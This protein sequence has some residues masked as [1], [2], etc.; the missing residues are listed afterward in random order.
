MN[1][2]VEQIVGVSFGVLLV[3]YLVVAP[4]ICWQKGKQVATVI[5]IFVPIVWLLGAVKY[6]KPGSP[7]VERHYDAEKRRKAREHFPRE[8]ARQDE[9][10]GLAVPDGLDAKPSNGR[11][12]RRRVPISA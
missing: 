9:L 12:G 3:V 10:D 5:G 4:Y 1:A 7:W 2:L 8:A 11:V 6:A